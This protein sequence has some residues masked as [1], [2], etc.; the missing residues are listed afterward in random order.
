MPHASPSLKDL[1]S[2]KSTFVKSTEF[3]AGENY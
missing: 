1:A 2:E 3:T